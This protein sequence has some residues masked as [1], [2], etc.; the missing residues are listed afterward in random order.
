MRAYHNATRPFDSPHQTLIELVMLGLA[1]DPL[2][3]TLRIAK[4]AAYTESSRR[5]RMGLAAALRKLAVEL[6]V[7][8]SK[9]EHDP[10]S[11]GSYVPGG[12]R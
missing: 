11:E 3:T 4:Q 5:A 9:G 1:A 12:S 2:S 10:V 8:P 6:E 7:T